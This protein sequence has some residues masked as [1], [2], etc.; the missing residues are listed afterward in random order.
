MKKLFLISLVC[1]LAVIFFI[2][3]LIKE[4]KEITPIKDKMTARAYH[5]YL[6]KKGYINEK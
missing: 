6:I 5:K 2:T 3:F 4:T 1:F